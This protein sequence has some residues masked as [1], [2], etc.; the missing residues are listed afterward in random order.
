M[1]PRLQEEKPLR[2]LPEPVEMPSER[3]GLGASASPMQTR[4]KTHIFNSEVINH[5]N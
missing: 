3:R 1:M 5:Q 2:L 4:R